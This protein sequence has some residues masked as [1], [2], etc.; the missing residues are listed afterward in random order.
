M[1]DLI[2][3]SELEISSEKLKS[4]K[5][6]TNDYDK[7]AHRIGYLGDHEEFNRKGGEL[8]Q[9]TIKLREIITKELQN[10]R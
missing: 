4:I 5:D 6:L 8:Y 10:Y 1:Q 9:K 2:T 3:K 7:F